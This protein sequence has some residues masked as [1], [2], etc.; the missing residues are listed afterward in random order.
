M[1]PD[2]PPVTLRRSL[3]PLSMTLYGLGTIVGAGIFVLIGEVI[4][5]SGSAAPAAFVLAAFIAALTGLSYAQLASRHPSSAGEAAYVSAA[6][7]RDSLT[8]VVGLAVAL[9]GMVS[10][11]TM[12]HGFARYL[13]S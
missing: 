7:A 8:L 1:D 2:N 4:G 11:A 5:V 13:G 10:A 3:G 12:A 9:S 6:F